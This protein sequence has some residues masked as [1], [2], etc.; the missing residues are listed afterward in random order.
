MSCRSISSAVKQS[1]DASTSNMSDHA[2]K[3]LTSSP[4][5]GVANLSK[6]KPF[7][8]TMGNMANLCVDDSADCLDGA[9]TMQDSHLSQQ[10]DAKTGRSFDRICVSI[11]ST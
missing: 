5:T 1:E 3:L 7:F 10:D 9:A 11:V 8:N 6:L 4:N 2:T